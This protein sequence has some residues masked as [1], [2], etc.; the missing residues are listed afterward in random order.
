MQLMQSNQAIIIGLTCLF[1]LAV[2]HALTLVLSDTFPILQEG[3][4]RTEA[5]LVTLTLLFTTFR[6][7]VSAGRGT[8]RTA[9][10]V[11]E[12]FRAC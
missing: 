2:E 6:V 1:L 7:L 4:F 3:A 9:R 5:A 10:V 8:E 12:A 11:G